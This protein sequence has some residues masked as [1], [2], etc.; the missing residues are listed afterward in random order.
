MQKNHSIISKKFG[1]YCKIC[2][3]WICHMVMWPKDTDRMSHSVDPDQSAPSGD[4]SVQ[5]CV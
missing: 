3:V 4:I 5:S 1:K 2:I